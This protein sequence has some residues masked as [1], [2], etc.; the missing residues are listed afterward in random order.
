MILFTLVY[1]QLKTK[2]T[3]VMCKTQIYDVFVLR[4]ISLSFLFNLNGLR[5]SFSN[6]KAL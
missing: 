4:E 6:K 5:R 2:F 3:S 1:P